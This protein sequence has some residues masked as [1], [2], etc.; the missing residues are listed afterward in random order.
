MKQTKASGS[1]DPTYWSG[2]AV[3]VTGGGGFLG[4]PTV[5]MLTTLGAE[6]K[7]IR[8]ADRDLRDPAACDD[9]LGGA[10]I[11]LHLA[12]RVGGIGYNQ[13][14][15]GP[16]CFDNLTMGANV[17]EAA[18]KHGVA[19]LVC[20]SSACSYPRLSPT[21]FR[22]E[23]IW[24]GYPDPSNAPYGLAKKTLLVLADAYWRQY[25]LR[26]SC[27]VLTNLFGPGD[28][29]DLEDS[30]VVAAMIQKYV[31]ATE[32]GDAEVVLWGSGEPT[33]EFLYVDDAARALL[34]AA[35]RC[36]S[37]EPMNVGTG[38]EVRIRD[39]AELIAKASGHG[40]TTTWDRSR[41]DGQM[42]RCMDVGRA[43]DWIGFAPRTS[44]EDG[45]DR[46]VESFRDQ[47]RSS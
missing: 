19:K 15:P 4:R 24:D 33:R 43:R 42:R 12:A 30:H 27:P 18:R 1:P 13:R 35:E 10:E 37:P 8:S 32:E 11:V 26:T 34:L 16:L 21:P 44:L 17:F 5:R 47:A 41:P 6:V 7:V 22:E 31:H 29:Y 38:Q 40:G 9:A 46:A 14:N 39:L 3:A 23:N 20:V 36:E 25:G 45:L 28:N 2:R